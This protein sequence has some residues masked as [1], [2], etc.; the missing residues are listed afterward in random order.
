MGTEDTVDTSAS[1]DPERI[2]ELSAESRKNWSR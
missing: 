1:R 2:E